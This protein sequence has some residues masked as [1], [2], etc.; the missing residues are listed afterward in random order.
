MRS[1]EHDKGPQLD[2]AICK[3]SQAKEAFIFESAV[4]SK[5]IM[6]FSQ[7]SIKCHKMEIIMEST[8]CF[9]V[10]TASILV[11]NSVSFQ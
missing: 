1:L 5:F 11:F 7:T 3:G 4:L 10:S 2:S 6:S 9:Y 8:I